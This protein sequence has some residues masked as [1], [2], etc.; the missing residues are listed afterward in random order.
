MGKHRDK[1]Q[2]DLVLRGFATATCE[3]YLRNASAFIAHFG[4]SADALGTEEVRGWV[5]WL[6]TVKKLDA[7]TVNVAIASLR[8]LFATLGRPEVMSSVRGV[9]KQHREPDVLSGS[10]V[11]RLLSASDNIKHR[12]LFTLLYGA[13][14][15][16]AELL[17]LTVADIDSQR[18]VIHLRN[19]KNRH[20]RMVP[21]S[22]RMLHTLREYW[23]AR[24]PKGPL[25]FPGRGAD[26][27]LTRAAVSKAIGKTARC[28]AITK[29][30]HPHLLRH[31]FA[32]HLLELG[33]DLRTVQI[34]LGHRSLSST[35]RYTHLTEARRLV[36][37][38]PIEAL[39]TEQ[40]SILG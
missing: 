3:S 9:R 8:F 34:L 2:Q 17:S 22:P 20:D 26:K 36:L 4:R 37:R 15:R 35:A 25:L 31:A 12:A 21:L 14:L 33:T 6:L 7:S 1:M 24:R 18:M 39:G 10:E 16:V 11:E 5:L 40:A 13:G 30:V 19:T 32:T 23:R 29:K 28:A 38:S 27:P